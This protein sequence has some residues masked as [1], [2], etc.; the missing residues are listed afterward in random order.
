MALVRLSSDSNSNSEFDSSS[1]EEDSSDSSSGVSA[2]NTSVESEAQSPVMAN[3]VYKSPELFSFRACDWKDWLKGYQRFA[4]LT[5]TDKADQI[6]QCDSLLHHMGGMKA[7]AIVKTFKW[8][9]KAI[10]NP[11][12][13]ATDNNT[14]PQTIDR[15]ES[16]E[17]YEDLEDK[18]TRHFI[19]SVNIINE[20]TIFNK[21]VQQEGE[22]ERTDR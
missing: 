18:F 4:R 6:T 12:Y 11:A 17:V 5:K 14:V 16:A 9:K 3:F 15:D 2:L 8:G 10:P 1:G 21:R 13:H 19:P 20:S 22:T 7:D